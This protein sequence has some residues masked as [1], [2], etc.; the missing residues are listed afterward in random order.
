[1]FRLT[2]LRVA[3]QPCVREDVWQHRVM[4]RAELLA[5]LERDGN[6]FGDACA[7]ASLD[8]P[9]ASCPGWTVADLVWHLATAHDFWRTVVA[10]RLADW[11][12]YTGPERPADDDLIALYRNG[13]TAVHEV[14]T[15][16]ESTIEIWTWSADKTAGFVIRRLAHETAVH[17]W[18]AEHAAGRSNDLEAELASDGIDEFLTHF[19][20]D[21]R[22]EAEPVGGSVHIHCQDV[23]GEWTLRPVDT[24]AAGTGF[25]VTREHAKGDCAIRGSASDVVLALWRRIPLTAGTLNFAGD[26]SIAERFIAR[27]S[28]D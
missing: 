6:A 19:L 27:T 12:A 25:D 5:A 26:Q 14:L 4:E 15:A 9:V 17:R 18:D 7:A 3:S 20:G 1:M 2:N 8:A 21:A 13:L 11:K 28:L 24:D 23:A 22:A 10:D 16:T